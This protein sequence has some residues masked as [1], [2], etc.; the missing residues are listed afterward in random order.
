MRI[1]AGLPRGKA[2]S[3]YAL[4]QQLKALILGQHEQALPSKPAEEARPAVKPERRYFTGEITS[5]SA[6]SGMIDQQV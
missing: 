4:Y 5:L 2:G 3:M 6:S 1:W